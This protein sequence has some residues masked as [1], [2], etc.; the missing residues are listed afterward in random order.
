MVGYKGGVSVYGKIEIKLKI[1]LVQHD[2]LSDALA[3]AEFI[4][5]I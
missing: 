5:R 3:F 1:T 2:A 4:F